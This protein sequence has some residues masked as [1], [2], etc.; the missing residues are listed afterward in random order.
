M[1]THEQNESLLT[2]VRLLLSEAAKHEQ[3]GTCC[4]A[5]A[6][7]RAA[8]GALARYLNIEAKRERLA[9]SPTI[10]INRE[11]GSMQ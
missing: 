7:G 6:F 10:C 4:Y 8:A 5:D 11:L 9:R 1:R 2:E 3:R